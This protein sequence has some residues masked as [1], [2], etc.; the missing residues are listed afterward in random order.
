MLFRTFPGGFARIGDGPPVFVLGELGRIAFESSSA[1]V[2]PGSDVQRQFPDRVR[3]WNR[4]RRGLRCR[5]AVQQRHQRWSMP[6]VAVKS[7]H[8]LIA[9]TFNFIHRPV[10]LRNSVN[11]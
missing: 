7:T 10:I 2:F 8:K 9:D 4:M 3:A 11:R 5:H 6:R 1:R